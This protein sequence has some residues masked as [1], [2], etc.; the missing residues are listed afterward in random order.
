M[1]GA[2]K[3]VILIVIDVVV[4]V[5]RVAVAIAQIPTELSDTRLVVDIAKVGE[6]YLKVIILGFQLMKSIKRRK[7]KYGEN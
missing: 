5:V 7:E 2:Q 4:I 6:T 3:I 1:I